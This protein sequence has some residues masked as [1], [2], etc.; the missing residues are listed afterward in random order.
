MPSSIL[1]V[2]QVSLLIV[3][4]EL[5]MEELISWF[6]GLDSFEVLK[7]NACKMYVFPE[8]APGSIFYIPAGLLMSEK[9]TGGVLFYGLRRSVLV[10]S[11]EQAQRRGFYHRKHFLILAT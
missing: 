5:L 8:T 1:A 2:R 10:Q 4:A 3:T 11:S 9:V 7:Q 6:N